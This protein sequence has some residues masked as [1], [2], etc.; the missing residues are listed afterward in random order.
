MILNIVLLLVGFVLLIK[1]ADVLV[2]GSSSVAKKF[3]ISNVVIGLTIVAFGT[4]APELI[5]NIIASINGNSDIGMG[6]VI[7]SNI[8]NILLI[9]GVAALFSNLKVDSSIIKKQIP[10]SILAVVALFILINSTILNKTGQDGLMRSGGLILILFFCIFLY[11]TFSVA[12]KSDVLKEENKE[13]KQLSK[14]TSILMIISGVVA[15]F[16]GGK[17]I[18]DSSVFIAS[19]LGLSQA[20]IGL[21]IVAVGTSLPELAASVMAARKNQADMAIGNVVGSNI[22]NILW[23]LGLSSI[24]SPISYNP[25]MNFDIIFL[26]IVS[27]ILF[28][29]IFI[30]KKYHFTKKEGFVLIGLYIAYLI[31]IIIRG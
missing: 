8:A 6:N 11:Y 3:G 13:I 14:R 2:D 29:L 15:L 30:G 31:Y 24:I 16:F 4:S 28:P 9:L 5:V 23:I 18:V 21:T 12:K 17:F 27:V 1:G 10:F 19:S 20:L 25:A 7:G 26:I 22:F